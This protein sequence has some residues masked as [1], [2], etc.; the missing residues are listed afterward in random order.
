MRVRGTGKGRERE[1]LDR[2]M[3]A[4]LSWP[5]HFW[6]SKTSETIVRMVDTK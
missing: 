2:E 6:G 4:F 5:S 1:S 3:K